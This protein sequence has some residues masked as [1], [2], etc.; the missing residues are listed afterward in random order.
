VLDGSTR[1][2]ELAGVFMG[3]APL[4]GTGGSGGG[5]PGPTDSRVIKLSQ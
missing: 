4:V 5:Q 3:L 1:K 2:S